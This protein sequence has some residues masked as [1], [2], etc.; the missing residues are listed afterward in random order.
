MFATQLEYRLSLPKRLGVVGF[1]GTGEVVPGG[2]QA[3]RINNL[4]SAGGGGARFQLSKTYRVNLRADFARG[5]D[6]WTWSMGVGE[7]F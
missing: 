7:A 6:T 5:K 4:L 3:F 1:G 2:S